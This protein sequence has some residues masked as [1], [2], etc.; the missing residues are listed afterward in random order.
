MDERLNMARKRELEGVVIGSPI[1]VAAYNVYNNKL[2]N[3]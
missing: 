2:A 1:L 3:S